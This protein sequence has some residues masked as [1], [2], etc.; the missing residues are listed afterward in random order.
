MSAN[1]N[2]SLEAA[3][4]IVRAAAEYGADAIKLQTFTPATLTIDSHRPE[5]F[6]D[7]ASSLWHG[8]R[9]WDLYEEA[10][11]PWEW[12]QPI[13]ELARKEGL[14]CISSAFDIASIR[15]LSSLGVDAIKIASHELIHIPLIE[16]AARSGKPVL[17]SAGMASIE[18]L[19]EAVGVL[20]GNGC[21]QFILLKCTS[22]YPADEADANVLT[23]TEMRTRCGCQ[24]GLSD[25]TIHPYVAFAATALG[26]CVIEKHFTMARA[27][28][29]LDAAFSIEPLELREFATGT[30][31]VWKSLGKVSFGAL[32]VEEASVKERPSI[33]VVRSMKEGEEFTEQNLRIIRPSAGLAPKHYRG[34]IGKT[35]ACDITAETPMSWDMVLNGAAI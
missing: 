35:C 12:H 9:L 22:A 32:G 3:Q 10:H 23:I 2:G 16:E 33:Y 17:L 11:T 28:G 26:A 31:M 1:H 15:F 4:R 24:V 14:A 6:I 30:E 19:D 21:E 29:G 13:F 5:F 27:D 8:R 20:R 18:E 34:L 7:D 25:H